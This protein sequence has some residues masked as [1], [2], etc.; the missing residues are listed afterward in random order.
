MANINYETPKHSGNLV[1]FTH[2]V[3]LY[4]H[5]KDKWIVQRSC[6]PCNRV[7]C[8]KLLTEKPLNKIHALRILEKINGKTLV[9]LSWDSSVNEWV[10]REDISL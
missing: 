5:T 1:P 9:I 2:Q 3:L 10:E 6:L 7:T 4:L 8:W